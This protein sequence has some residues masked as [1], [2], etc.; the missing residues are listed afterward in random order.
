MKKIA[1]N[2]DIKVLGAAWDPP[3]W[4]KTNGDWIGLS[5]LREEYYQTWT[6]YHVKYLELHNERNERNISFLGYF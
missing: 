5:A 3:K 1:E 6:D 4:M 2:D